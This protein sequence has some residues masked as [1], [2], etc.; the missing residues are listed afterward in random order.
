MTETVRTTITTA[1]RML[2]VS[3]TEGEMAPPA[4]YTN[5]IG[6]PRLKGL[7]LQFISAGRFGPMTEVLITEDYE[8]GENERITVDS[9]VDLDIT[10]PL[11]ISDTNAAG[12]TVDRAVYDRSVV[13][14]T[15]GSS[16][17]YDAGQTVDPWCEIEALTL[18]SETPLGARYANHIA[19]L[20]AVDI[21][22]ECGVV[23]SSVVAGLAETARAILRFKPPIRVAIDSAV[24]RANPRIF[25]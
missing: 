5:T 20:L 23:P 22:P 16:Y 6:L 1:L 25:C 9:D 24:L 10:L 8:A 11:I 4:Y 14:I 3:G 2:G 19:A 21:S 17:L 12:T 13:Q 7:Y 15:G 18:D